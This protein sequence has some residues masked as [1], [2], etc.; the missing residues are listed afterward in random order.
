M[1]QLNLPTYLFIDEEQVVYV[2]DENNHCVMKWKKSAK[3]GIMVAGRRGEGSA[4]TLL[5]HSQ[6]LFVD[7]S[8]TLYVADPC[9]RHVM[10]SPKVLL[11]DTV[12]VGIAP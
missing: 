8:G 2:S 4:L 12:I 6:E 3:K 10:R 7:T 9:H 11:Q 5:H 1:N